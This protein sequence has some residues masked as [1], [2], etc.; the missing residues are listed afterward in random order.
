MHLTSTL[1]G[2]NPQILSLKKFLIFFTYFE[3]VSYIYLRKVF[4]IFRERYM[5]S[6]GIFRTLVYSETDTYS[7]HCQTSMMKRFAKIAT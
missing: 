6:P 7:E 5:L 2:L 1:F 3:K 4:L